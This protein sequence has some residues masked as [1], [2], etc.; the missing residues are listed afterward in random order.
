[1]PNGVVEKV[2]SMLQGIGDRDAVLATEYVNA[3]K[4]VEHSP[5]VRNGIEGLVDFIDW[6]PH[7]KRDFKVVRVFQE[8]DFAVAHSEGLIL[9]QGVFFDL[10]KFVDG[11]VIERWAFSAAA[12]PPNKS[13]HTQTDGPSQASGFANT[14]KNK[15]FV[16]EYYE[17][18]HVAGK[19]EK[20]A[21][22]FSGNDCIRHE[23]GV[24]DGVNNFQCDLEHLVKN[25][26]IN[27]I[28]FLL[29]EGNFVFIAA[30]GTVDDAPCTY[31]D[32][33]RVENGKIAERWGF[34]E[35]VPPLDTLRISNGLL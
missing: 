17:T 33:Y 27:Q 9:D 1:M 8:G 30:Q 18:I 11:L 32:L 26:S 35:N 23:P 3:D 4:Y 19:H 7:P 21:H 20:I 34:S 14:E 28:E 24:S 10:F 2:R 12:A 16:R 22:Y 5:Y 6:L 15:A 31:L 25:R 29:G 13:G